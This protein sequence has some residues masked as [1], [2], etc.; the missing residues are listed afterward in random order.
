MPWRCWFFAIWM[1]AL[2]GGCGVEQEVVFR[3]VDDAEV[4]LQSEPDPALD[5]DAAMPVARLQ[6]T[7]VR[8]R[9]G[10]GLVTVA[11]KLEEPAPALLQSVYQLRDLEAQSRC[12][13][14]DFE[15]ASGPL[16][17]QP[18]SS[19]AELQL[20]VMDDDLAEIDEALEIVVQPATGLQGGSVT[21]LI[22]DDDRSALLHASD[23]GV[24]PNVEAP[25]DV[26]LQAA[27]D[28]A[29][30]SG[31]GVLTL[32]SGTYAVGSVTVP[33]GVTL[34]G[35]SATLRRPA[36]APSDTVT[37]NVTH[38]GQDDS[39]PTLIEGVRI[40]G[41][42]DQQGV[43][44]EKQLEDAHLIALSAAPES[45]GRLRASVL[46]TE[47]ESGTADGVFIGTNVDAELCNI[48]AHDLWRDAVGVLGGNTHVHLHGLVASASLGTTG[49]W[50]QGWPSGHAGSHRL[51][52][53][54]SDILLDS[55]DL[56]IQVEGES[57]I[58]ID[59]LI[60][61][62]PPLRVEALDSSVHITN[63]QLNLGV[64][65]E[66][67]NTWALLGEV[68]IENTTLI[69][70]EVIDET[71]TADEQDRSFG[72]VTVLWD[73]GQS[74]PATGKLQLRDCRFEADASIE[75]SDTIYAVETRGQGEHIRLQ[76]GHLGNGV[77]DWFSPECSG[78]EHH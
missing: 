68:I 34:S 58:T 49:L 41:Q 22:E 14:P 71:G 43:F 12:R 29:H 39:L 78:C 13:T 57:Q 66:R 3:I 25:Q 37:L 32:A 75:P 44:T 21:V 17:W 76:G 60:M 33:A 73:F 55:G 59:E 74:S 50:F 16:Q 70:S 46:D 4:G 15:A 53:E 64:P 30:E 40:D 5:V 56:E 35:R 61:T 54:L 42:R 62:A 23:F 52:L 27:L 36:S 9:E 10:A 1:V 72:I 45:P 6:T 19:T 8:V 31:R 7:L 38:L 47:L 2:A 67:H 69:A 48:Q 65:S 24:V 51:E 11:L 28:A 63:S 18:G 26:A 20:R 77:T